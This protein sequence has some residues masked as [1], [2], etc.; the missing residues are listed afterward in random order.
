MLMGELILI[1]KKGVSVINFL[2]SLTTDL[3]S[4]IWNFDW[5]VEI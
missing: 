2:V 5:I 3:G 4:L 1:L